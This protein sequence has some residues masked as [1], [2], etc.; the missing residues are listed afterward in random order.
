MCRTSHGLLLLP[1]KRRG[2]GH[3]PRAKAGLAGFLGDRTGGRSLRQQS[4]LIK[5]KSRGMIET[6]DEFSSK[7]WWTAT[8]IVSPVCHQYLD[9]ELRYATAHQ[10]LQTCQICFM[11]G[12]DLEQ[13]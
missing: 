10:L 4:Y 5:G 12:F 3:A 13:F 11:S 9:A 2:A 1:L 7:A 8:L 6:C